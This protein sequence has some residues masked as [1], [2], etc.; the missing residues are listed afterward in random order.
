MPI[1]ADEG[2]I[3]EAIIVL[4]TRCLMA[5]HGVWGMRPFIAACAGGLCLFSA[6]SALGQTV[7]SP[8]S[9]SHI[10]DRFETEQPATVQPPSASL[11][12]ESTNPPASADQIKLTVN[13]FVFS[14]NSVYGSDELEALAKGVSGETNLQTVYE[15]AAA[16][17]GKYSEDGY[18][19]TRAI[20]PPQELDPNGAVVRI[21]II[22][23]YIDEVVWPAEVA[24][25][26][27]VF[28]T[29]SARITASRPLNIAV[30]ERYLLLANDLPGL[31]FETTLEPSEQNAGAA[32]LIVSSSYKAT[33]FSASVDN[34]GTEGRGPYQLS[35]SGTASNL[36]K[37]QER[38]SARWAGSAEFEELQYAEIRAEK[39]LNAEG[40]TAGVQFSYDTGEP[41][42]EALRTLEFGSESISL[43]ADLTYPL[44]RSR[45][46]NL[47][48][49]G[50]VFARAYR[51][52]ALGAAFN[53]DRLR[54]IRLG[55]RYDQFDRFNGISRLEATYSQGIEGLGSTKN[56]NP[57]ASRS[58]GRVDFTKIELSGSRSQPLSDGWSAF[59]RIDGQISGTPLLSSEECTYGG[60]AFG[61][62]FDP[63]VLSGDHCVKLLGELRYNVDWTDLGLSQSQ[64]YAF[65]DYG[66]VWR[67]APGVGT[68]AADDASSVGA[69]LRLAWGEHLSGDIEIGHKLSGPASVDAWRFGFSLTARH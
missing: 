26:E 30:L 7:P 47:W 5:F 54:G 37:H 58:N 68:P 56:E 36:L 20:V 2:L 64:V 63:S 45:S 33:G 51:S 41:G 69:G 59:G 3:P 67:M 39:V 14:G 52:D 65:S 57:L 42:T 53:E 27:D 17:T 61:R 19:L 15:L 11:Q 55:F 13:R 29:Y 4:L 10:A 50:T 34:K 44:I 8:E 46:H 38:F 28:S 24:A 48:L 22:E 43:S 35:A 25:F 1:Q 32:R 23:G 12:L 31:S 62:A 40:L 6:S 60:S 49:T 18:I 9:G 66:R 21:E 16:I